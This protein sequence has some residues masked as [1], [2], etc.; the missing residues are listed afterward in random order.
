LIEK[1]FFFFSNKP[2]I[3]LCMS[4]WNDIFLYNMVASW[5]S[6]CSKWISKCLQSS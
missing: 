2:F 4:W 6:I 3:F 5:S 1:G